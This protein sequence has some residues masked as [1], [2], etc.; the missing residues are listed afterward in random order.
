VREVV[1][2][3]GKVEHMRVVVERE[4]GK[5]ERL[6]AMV[7]AWSVGMSSRCVMSSHLGALRCTLC[8]DAHQLTTRSAEVSHGL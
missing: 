4:H 1:H 8:V 5:V 6:C 3:R 7:D 2:E